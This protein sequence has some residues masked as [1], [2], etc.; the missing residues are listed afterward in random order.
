MGDSVEAI[1]GCKMRIVP[2]RRMVHGIWHRIDL[3]F[4]ILASSGLR[5]FADPLR[6]CVCDQS[7]FRDLRVFLQFQTYSTDRPR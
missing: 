3:H 7:H 1:Q 2:F 5:W 6:R 4:P